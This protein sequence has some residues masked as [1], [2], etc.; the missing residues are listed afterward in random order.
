M[1]VRHEVYYSFKSP[2]IF[3]VNFL[4]VWFLSVHQGVQLCVLF[5]HVCERQTWL[6]RDS[7]D[8]F[9]H[10][11]NDQN[12]R[13]LLYHNCDFHFCAAELYLAL[14]GFVSLFNLVEI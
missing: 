5:E 3:K 14:R 9:M 11:G 4:A 2:M 1:T 12:N 7:S 6:I 8:N 10:S 13:P